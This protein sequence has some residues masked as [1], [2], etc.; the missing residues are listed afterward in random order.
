MGN[1]INFYLLL[2]SLVILQA[3]ST[4]EDDSSGNNN[5]DF[6]TNLSVGESAYDLLSEDHFSKLTLEIAYMEGFPLT[7]EALQE[8][9]QFLEQ[10]LHKSQGVAIIQ[11]EIPAEEAENYSTTDL[12][13]IEENYRQ[14]FPEENEISIWISV[15]DGYNENESVVGVAYRNLSTSLMGKTISENAG[16]FNQPSKTSIEASILMHELGHLLG[17]VDVGTPMVEDHAANGNH[18]DN[19]DCLMY[20][21]VETT[22]FF[23]I[24]FSTQIPELDANCK[25]DLQANG[26]K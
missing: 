15:V 19:E 17:L 8:V 2:F 22:D 20:F 11:T 3:C 1:K 14:V 26:G 5:A 21:A 25:Q 18:C 16:G 13:E 6:S 9:T 7:D 24:L 10:H 4:D 23:S 12:V